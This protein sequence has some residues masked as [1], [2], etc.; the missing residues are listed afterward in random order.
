[1]LE[2][3]N[4]IIKNVKKIM[5]ILIP[6]GFSII[7]MNYRLCFAKCLNVAGKNINKYFKMFIILFYSFAIS[8]IK[9]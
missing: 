2:K 6:L 1:M 3:L 7:F 9:S 8:T 4:T 5:L